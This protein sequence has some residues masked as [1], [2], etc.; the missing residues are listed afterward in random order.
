MHRL[1]DNPSKRH[2]LTW[3]LVALLALAPLAGFGPMPQAAADTT[4][5]AMPC[6]DAP[7]GLQGAD[8][9]GCPDCAAPT[10][11]CCPACHG[12]PAGAM[13]TTTALLED[14]R[15]GPSLIPAFRASDH[16]DPCLAGLYRP[17]NTH[18][19]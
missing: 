14:D 11:D 17:P 8:G 5:S 2:A 18:S 13:P 10:Q 9:T 16:P 19:A 7:A 1:S 3:V 6:H 4:A 12:V 15:D